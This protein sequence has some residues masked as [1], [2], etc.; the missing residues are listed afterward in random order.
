VRPAPAEELV[1][2][3][4]GAGELR[5]S[6]MLAERALHHTARGLGVTAEPEP[7]QAELDR[8]WEHRRPLLEF[9]AAQESGSFCVCDGPEGLVGYARVLRFEGMEELTQIMVEPAYQGM[10]IGRALLERCWPYVPSPQLGRVVVA[11]GSMAD[12]TLYTEFGLMP[13]TG[14]WHLEQR[15][16]EYVERRSHETL[17]GTEAAVHLLDGTRAA[18]E[19][20]RLEPPA[21]AHERPR[22]HEFFGRERIC[23]AS[24]DGASGSARALCWVSPDLGDIGPAVGETMEELVPVVLAALDRVAKSSEPENLHLFC[25]T[26]SW[27]LLRRLRALGFRV[28]WP[29]WILSSKPLPGLDRYAPTRPPLLL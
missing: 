27:W 19:W 25:T 8:L 20:G 26:D 9:M 10:G 5:D 17:D 1:Y 28:T 14:H 12:L 11:A 3:D 29:S 24:M 7:A 21:I 22:L 6:F 23:L 15:A 16:E 4:G 2:R 13:V 18:E